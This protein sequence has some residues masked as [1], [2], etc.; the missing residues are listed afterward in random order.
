[1]DSVHDTSSDVEELFHA[2]QWL[3]FF[4]HMLV[5]HVLLCML[6]YSLFHLHLASYITKL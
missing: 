3:D 1:M 6:V 5:V 4:C 2:T